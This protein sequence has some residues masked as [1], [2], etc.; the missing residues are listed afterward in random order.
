[1]TRTHYSSTATAPYLQ[2]LAV[3]LVLLFTGTRAFAPVCQVRSHAS[4]PSLQS[5]LA[6]SVAWRQGTKK[7]Q[8]WLISATVS[9]EEKPAGPVVK[10]SLVSAS[11]LVVLDIAFRRLL[12]SMSI[13]FP[14]SLAGCGV[15]FASMLTLPFGELIYDALSPGSTLLTKWLAVM[16][17]PSL[18]TLPLADGLGSA[19]EVR[20]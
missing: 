19:V 4:L 16:F 9:S 5:S 20:S 13:A 11:A 7:Q 8:K 1:M 3:A 15:L 17:V 14:S 2:L 10:K 12:Q 6:F 18:V